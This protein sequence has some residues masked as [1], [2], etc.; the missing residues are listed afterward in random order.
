MKV[1]P[2]SLLALSIIRSSAFVSVKPAAGVLPLHMVQADLEPEPSEGIELTSTLPMEGSPM[3]GTRMKKLEEAEGMKSEDGTVYKFWMKSVANEGLIKEYRET[4]LKDSKQKANFP[5][6]R[7]GVVPP[8][9]MGQIAK[10]AIQ[11]ALITTV[12]NVVDAFSLKSLPGGDG[13]VEIKESLDVFARGYKVGTSLEF[14]ATL[15]CAFNEDAITPEDGDAITP[16]HR[17]RVGIF[18]IKKN[19]LL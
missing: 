10:F 8:F 4:L 19:L 6:F 17:F 13:Q 2:L 9:A 18:G 1:F 5:G 7:K 12:G 3:E 14:T 15:N 11:E 16:D